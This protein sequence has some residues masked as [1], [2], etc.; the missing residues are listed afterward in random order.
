MGAILAYLG[1]GLAA[2]FADSVLKWIAFKAVMVFLFIIVVPLLLNNFLYDV[3]E[4]MMNFSNDQ[5][6]GA[7]ALNGNMTFSGFL[8]WLLTTVRIP[9]AFSI[10][11]SALV[12]RVTLS[13]IPFVRLVG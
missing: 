10:M 1:S 13:M 9:E 4:I 2:T 5:S 11:V 8:A 7:N 3:I 6:S 12:L